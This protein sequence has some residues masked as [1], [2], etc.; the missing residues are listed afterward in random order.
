MFNLIMIQ[1]TDA[2]LCGLKVIK[3]LERSLE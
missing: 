2:V 3:F 1:E